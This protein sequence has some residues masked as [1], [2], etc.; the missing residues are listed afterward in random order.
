MGK[1]AYRMV[2]RRGPTPGLILELSKSDMTIGRDLSNDFVIN[3]VEVSRKHL[4]L[5]LVGDQYR[6]E[7]LG[8]TNGTFVNGQ[9]LAGPHNLMPGE[10]LSLGEHVTL[11]YEAVPYDPAATQISGSMG[12]GVRP[13]SPIVP[14]KSPAQR[15]ASP[16]PP[17]PAMQPTPRTV[18]PEIESP[19]PVASEGEAQEPIQYAGQ[20][21][22]GPEDEPP[23]AWEQPRKKRLNLWLL[24][25]GGCLLV[26]I[27]LVIALWI[28]IDVNILYCT[29][30]F[31]II[32]RIF[33][34]CG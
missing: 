33:G 22:P 9:R 3:D 28:F 8:S 34:Y 19:Q 4:R 10:L 25:G 24:A 7:D 18:T 12:V 21:P 6:V 13:V 23:V 14:D 30:P 32:F 5:L 1:S 11:V 31:D 29:P 20:I 26:V 2:V 17:K 15:P 16:P 27:C